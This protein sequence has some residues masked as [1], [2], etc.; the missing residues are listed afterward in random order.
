MDYY[1]RAICPRDDANGVL[2]KYL[3]T[4]TQIEIYMCDECSCIWLPGESIENLSFLFVTA[5]QGR[6]KG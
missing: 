5:Q 2:I 4:P 6:Q 1:S 3:F